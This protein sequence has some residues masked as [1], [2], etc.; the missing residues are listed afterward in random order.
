MMGNIRWIHQ[1]TP[2]CDL[3]KCFLLEITKA[4]PTFRH[5]VQ[6]ALVCTPI[7]PS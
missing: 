7:Q 3:D 1:L 4:V 5:Y 6:E 2:A